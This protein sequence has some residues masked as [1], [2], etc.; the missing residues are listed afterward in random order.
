MLKTWSVK[1]LKQHYLDSNQCMMDIF[2]DMANK[3]I[4]VFMDDFSVLGKSFN[5][6]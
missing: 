4:E 3:K 5:N 6:F 1:G 2:A